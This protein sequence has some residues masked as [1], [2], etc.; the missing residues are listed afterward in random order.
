MNRLI[1]SFLLIFSLLGRNLDARGGRG[2]GGGGGGRGSSG[3]R[4][5]VG[6]RGGG[7]RGGGGGGFRSGGARSS[8]SSFRGG[9]SHYSS[10]FRQNVFHTSSTSRT[11]VFSPMTRTIVII[12]PASP[13]IYE[14]N[15]YYWAGHHVN[16]TEKPYKCDYQITYEDMELRHVTFANGTK[17]GNITFGCAEYQS[18]CGMECCTELSD[19]QECMIIIGV[20]LTAGLCLLIRRWV[21]QK[22][23]CNGKM[24]CKRDSR[25]TSGPEFQELTH[26]AHG[27]TNRVN[28]SLKT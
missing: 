26:R 2:R 12:S 1:W 21:R 22:G 11:F 19:F 17:P 3:A 6:G 23:Y 24:T 15:H 27:D 18:C 5:G 14:N 28:T 7:G 4:G 10:S 25:P 13:M 16:T 20:F 9:S 8:F